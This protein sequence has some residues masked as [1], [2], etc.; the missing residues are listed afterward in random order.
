M[1]KLLL[2]NPYVLIGIAAAFALS[3]G[4]AIW[5]K[6]EASVA[7]ESQAVA[8]RQAAISAADAERWQAASAVRDAT[9]LTCTT[10]L[11]QQSTLIS[12]GRAKE[13]QLRTSLDNARQQNDRLQGEADQLSRDLEDE[14]ARAPGDVVPLGPIVLRRV[15]ELWK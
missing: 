5:F 10:A 1:L 11:D 4:S 13:A 7:R 3:I 9:L 2:G 12:A 14:A 8:E 15:K 6:H